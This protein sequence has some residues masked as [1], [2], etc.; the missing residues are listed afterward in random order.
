MTLKD[1]TISAIKKEVLERKKGIGLCD[2]NLVE[3]R[4]TLRKEM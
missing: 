2:D 3:L 4:E 1:W